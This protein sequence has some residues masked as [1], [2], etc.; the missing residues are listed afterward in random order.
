MIYLLNFLLMF[1]IAYG[2]NLKNNRIMQSLNYDKRFNYSVASIVSSFF[3]LLISLKTIP[4]FPIEATL[5]LTIL[6]YMT[7]ISLYSDIMYKTIN[8]W[9]LRY[10]YIFTGICT[11]VYFYRRPEFNTNMSLVI[12]TM[13]YVVLIAFLLFVHS[14]GSS[15]VRI[16]MALMP[17]NFFLIGNRFLPFLLVGIVLSM[18]YQKI[19]RIRL[20]AKKLELPVSQ[21]ISVPLYLALLTFR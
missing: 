14:I 9:M 5:S 21:F 19:E 18:V 7:F 10:A 2:D 12:L 13:L 1:C 20:D 11:I 16:F 15:D 17:I 3:G 4:S 6:G 8:R